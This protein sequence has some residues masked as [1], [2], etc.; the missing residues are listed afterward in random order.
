VNRFGKVKDFVKEQWF[1][2]GLEKYN[3]RGGHVK[4]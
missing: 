1:G 4:S 3:V 2:D